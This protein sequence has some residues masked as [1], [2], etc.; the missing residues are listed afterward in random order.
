MYLEMNEMHPVKVPRAGEAHANFSW[1]S[2]AMMGMS[3][4]YLAAC[5]LCRQHFQCH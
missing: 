3:E 2:S 1:S 5:Y 4:C